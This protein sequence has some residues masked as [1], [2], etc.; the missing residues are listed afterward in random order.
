VSDAPIAPA[1]SAAGL[2]WIVPDWPAP[3]HVHALS[4]TRGGAPDRGA[5]FSRHNAD[6]ADARALLRRFVPDDPIWLI[7][8]HGTTV[9]D[10]DTAT[11][12]PPAA[13][14]MVAHRTNR[15][16]AVSSADCL[17]VLFVD[18]AGNVVAAAHAGWRGLSAGV[19][20]ASVTAMGVEPRDVLSWLGPAIGPRAFEVGPDVLRAFC[21]RDPD[22]AAC[23]VPTGPQKWHADLYALAR[24]RLAHAG[25]TDVYGGGHCTFS[26]PA[27]FYSYRR[28]GADAAR[29]M[30]TA[31]WRSPR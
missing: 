9:H 18:R 29:R 13:D 16:C 1:L 6:V 14:A 2:D 21:D 12:A 22:A 11:I 3:A 7:Q 8:Q 28:G 25:V 24:R 20:E 15:V 10:A 17:P 23:F 27:S 30:V 5:D 26:E 4:T 19:L 31:I